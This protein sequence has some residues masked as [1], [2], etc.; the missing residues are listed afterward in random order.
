MPG[1]CSGGRNH[2]C[3]RRG[4]CNCMPQHN[5]EFSASAHVYWGRRFRHDGCSSHI[6]AQSWRW[7]YR[8]CNAH[9]SVSLPD[10]RL[11]IVGRKSQ[12][13]RFPGC[14]QFRQFRF[15]Q[16]PPAVPVGSEKVGRNPDRLAGGQI[17]G[18]PPVHADYR[19]SGSSERLGKPPKKRPGR[20]RA[21]P[22]IGPSSAR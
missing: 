13:P 7:I 9:C 8:N 15:R 14:P 21:Q 5:C 1:P 4:G 3:W 16:C 10:Y 11:E 19:V 2:D 6:C 20:R 12:G 22:L 17:F 18:T